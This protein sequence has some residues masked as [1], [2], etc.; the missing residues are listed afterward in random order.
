MVAD[1]ET[2]LARVV[3]YLGV[4]QPHCSYL[5]AVPTPYPCYATNGDIP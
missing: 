2:A 4:E 1:T 3:A 5:F